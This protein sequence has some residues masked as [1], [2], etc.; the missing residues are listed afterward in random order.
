M[1][2]N[3]LEQGIITK[4]TTIIESTSG[5]LGVALAMICA[6]L[7]MKF[8]CVTDARSTKA[9]RQIIKAYGATLDI[10][11]EPDPEIGT[12]LAARLKRVQHLLDTIP[13]SY[14]LNQYQN[15][16]NPAAHHTTLREIVTKLDHKLD[17]LFC[18]TSTCGTLRG[19]SDYL[20]GNGYDTHIVAVD[21]RGS[22]IFGDLPNVRLIPGHGAGVM[23]PHYQHDL[24]DEHILV[25]DLDCVVGCKKL[26]LSEG[27]FAGGSSGGVM[28]AILK[29]KDQIPPQ[30]NVAA[31]LSDHGARYLDTIY[32]DEWVA[33]HFG[34][35]A[36]L[37]KAPKSVL[38]T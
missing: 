1:I 8:I 22:V 31:I 13:N 10:V 2:V 35:I 28:S 3:A 29:M 26:V 16:N 7:D 12:F 17:Y 34:D 25:S 36:D 32:D 38:T 4:D 21:A 37:I 24:E 11:E 20:R 27:I 9:N 19:A 5:N 15:P 6:Y 23:P 30:A 18:S 14:N 33:E